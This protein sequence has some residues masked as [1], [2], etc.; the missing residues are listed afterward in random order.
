M[1]AAIRPLGRGR[2]GGGCGGP[3]G[4]PAEELLPQKST[5]MEFFYHFLKKRN[6][7]AKI[8]D[9]IRPESTFTLRSSRAPPGSKIGQ[10]VPTAKHVRTPSAARS[11]KVVAVPEV[12]P[13]LGTSLR[14]MPDGLRSFERPR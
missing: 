9:S 5:R 2:G 12:V 6:V 11:S 7:H 14:C 8:I 1:V 13:A 10:L 3:V 4:A